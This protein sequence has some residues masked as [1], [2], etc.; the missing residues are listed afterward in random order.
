MTIK[1]SVLFISVSFIL[2]LMLFISPA[3]AYEGYAADGT[4]SGSMMGGTVTSYGANVIMVQHLIEVDQ[5]SNP[6]Y[7]KVDETIVFKNLGTGDYNGPLFSWLPDG[8]FNVGVAKLEMSAGGQ[9]RSLNI[10][11][12]DNNV[13]GW[14]D[15]ILS[16]AVMTPMYRLQYMVPAE[17]TGKMT[18]SVSFTKKLKYPTNVNYNYVPAS[19]MPSLVIKLVKSDDL[20]TSVVNEDGSKI[21]ADS[22]EVAEGSKTYN[23]GQPLF[24]EV[25]FVM[26]RS[27]VDQS[28]V[29]LYLV[30][31]LVILLIIGYPM[32]RGKTPAKMGLT[33]KPDKAK[34]ED[35]D[36]YWEQEEEELE[37][38]DEDEGDEEELEEDI[39]ASEDVEE[40]VSAASALNAEDVKSFDVDELKSAKK[41]LFKVLAELDED[42]AD[43]ALSEEE[44]NSIRDKYKQKAIGIMKQIDVLEE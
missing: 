36:L 21:E 11:M 31:L 10:F 1:N 6:G 39:E 14:N 13:V 17:P 33:N 32:L 5:V 12:A 20:K 29:S 40:D 41:A 9:I 26:S 23:W 18:E 8:A 3:C 15:T 35:D 16:G 38:E 22:V 19:G 7:L 44:Y 37:D 27:S 25:S 2:A 43:G 24:A 28:Q 4:E 42:Y 34:K 30:I